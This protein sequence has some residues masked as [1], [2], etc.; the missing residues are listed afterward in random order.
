[1]LEYRQCLDCGSDLY[2]DPSQERLPC[3]ICQSFKRRQFADY[4]DSI[5]VFDGYRIVHKRPG[6][7]RPVA[8]DRR[9]LSYFTKDGE[10]HIRKMMIDR[11]NNEYLER[12][13]RLS[14][15]ELVHEQ[16]H[17]LKDHVGHGDD[18]K[19]PRVP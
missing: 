15:G 17:T 8:E 14:T 1:M 11:A 2:E 10:W 12:I 18:K 9:E 3:P 7:K 13:T 19:N 5:T 16:R 4:E 6:V